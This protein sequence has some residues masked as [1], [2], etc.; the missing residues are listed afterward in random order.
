M[1]EGIFSKTE[2]EKEVWDLIQGPVELLG[3]SIVDVEL[4]PGPRGTVLRITIERLD[5]AVTI[6][7]CV[8]VSRTCG[9]ILDVKEPI[10]GPYNLEVSSPGINRPLKQL[11]DFE[12]FRAEKVEIKTTEKFHGRRRFKGILQGLRDDAVVVSVGDKTFE[13][14]VSIVR[15]AR[16][17]RI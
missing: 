6:D 14:P 11:Q 2:V 3:F 16:L 12:R 5:G 8:E 17:D 15:R 10:E 7:D 4:L 13:I 9:D 1:H